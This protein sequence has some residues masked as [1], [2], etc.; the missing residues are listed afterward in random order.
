[1]AALGFAFIAITTL[2]PQSGPAAFAPSLCV[3]CGDMAVQDIILNVI[4]FVP[5][6]A[7]MRLAGIRRDRVIAIAFC[8]TAV[9]EL[10]QMHIIPGRDSSLGD[11]ITNTFGAALGIALADSWPVWVF[12]TI[13]QARRQL[14]GGVIVW[15]TI[16]GATVWALHRSLPDTTL[17]GEWAPAVLHFDV[18]PGTIVSARAAGFA[19]PPGALGSD[20]LFRQRLLSD[21]VLVSAVVVPGAPTD[22]TAPIVSVYD[23]E[24]SQVFLLYQRQRSLAFSIRMNAARAMVRDPVIG[25]ANVFPAAAAPRDNGDTLHVA[26]GVLHRA[27]VIRA[28]DD[29]RHIERERRVPLGPALGWTFFLPWAYAFGNETSALSALW[30]GGLFLPL[31]YWSRRTGRRNEAAFALGIALVTGLVAAPPIMGGAF[32]GWAEWLGVI[33]GGGAG[34]W[35]G[36]MSERL[37]STSHEYPESRMRVRGDESV[38][39]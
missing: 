23:S 10:L 19:F 8:L 21:S 4:L 22:R 9:I 6:G 2:T 31:A 16:L 12:P 34:L 18:F 36:T 33:A 14:W 29:A 28:R 37:G 30:L 15:V 5:F 27:L 24:R 13:K 20:A 38:P 26:G 25:L 32:V 39:A 3:L 17:W 35:F 1:L 7:G 11:V